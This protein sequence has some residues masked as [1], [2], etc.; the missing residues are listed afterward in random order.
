MN[1]QLRLG[2]AA[3][4]LLVFSLLSPNLAQ[5]QRT[6]PIFGARSAA[7]IH[8]RPVGTH[9]MAGRPS[10]S[11]SSAATA[12][13]MSFNTSSN[14]WG[15]GDGSFLSL[16]DLLNPVPGLGFDYAHLAA[17][18]RDLG[19]KAVIDPATQWQLAVVE[20]VL[21]DTGGLVPAGGFFLLDGGGAYVVPAEAAPPQPP[22]QQPQIIVLQQ[23]PAAAQPSAQPEPPVVPEAAPPLPDVG[24]FTLALRSGTKIQAVAFTRLND[25]I[26]YITADGSRR[27]IALSDLDSAATMRIN[28]ERGTPLHLPL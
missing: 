2:L 6:A 24:S 21:R 5:G 10:N 7:P 19:I 1:N 8:A 13:A 15:F 3:A 12:R 20:R 26:V 14:A 9:A 18:N 4:I 16:Q 22:T 11:R 17:I 27:T 23:A 28:D 25:R